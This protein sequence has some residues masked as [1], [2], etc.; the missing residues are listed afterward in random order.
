M[1]EAVKQLEQALKDQPAN[2]L[3]NHQVEEY[4]REKSRLEDIAGSPAWQT[5]ANRGKAG[6]QARE[7]AK[8]LDH[9]VAKPVQGEKK[10]LI[11]KLADEVMESTIRPALIPREDMR[12]N[13]AGSVGRFMRVENSKPIKQ[14]IQHWKRAQLALEPGNE[15]PDLANVERFRPERIH[16]ANGTSTFMANAQIPGHF[17]MTPA[18]KENWPLGEPKVETP[19]KQAQKKERTQAQIDALARAQE[20][21]RVKR[22]AAAEAKG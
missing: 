4:Q 1:S 18:A 16:D 17:A 11:A 13:P 2:P 22:A 7:L 20:A 8:M 3:R 5:G 6:Q 15:D 12:R 19:L 21:A 10:D 14:A 9:Q